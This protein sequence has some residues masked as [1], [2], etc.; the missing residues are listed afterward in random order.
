MKLCPIDYQA[1]DVKLTGYLADGANGARAPGV[2]VAHEALGVTEHVKG[3]TAELAKQGYVAFALDLFGTHEL[4]LEEARRRSEVMMSTPGLIVARAAAAL[5]VLAKQ[6]HVDDTRLAAIGFCFGGITVL[7]LAR[8]RAAIKCAIGFHPGLKRPAGS[9]DG[10][11]SAKVLMMVG[12]LD[13]VAPPEDRRA[14]AESMTAAGADW[15]LH[16]FGGV[17]HSFT[18]PAI[19]EYGLPGFKY[20]ALAAHRSWEMCLALLREQTGPATK[21]AR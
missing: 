18:N 21:A 9:P 1:N 10:S 4:G 17:G 15:Q 16:I 2:L 6:R 12:D 3:R 8:H 14:F 20:D 7:E 11:I 5:D 19:D 13:P